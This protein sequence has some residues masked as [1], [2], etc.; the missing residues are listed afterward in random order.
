[1]AKVS[2]PSHINIDILFIY[3]PI[4]TAVSARYYCQYAQASVAA[5]CFDATKPLSIINYPLSIINYPLSIPSHINID[6][7][8][9]YC[10]IVTAVSARYYCQYAQASVAAICFDA[11]KPLSIINYPLSI[12]NYPLSIPSHINIDILF[13]YCPIVTAVSARYYCQYAQASVAAICFDAT[14]PLS[15]I[16]YPLSIINYPLS[17]PSHINIDILFI[18]CPIVTAVSA[19]YYCQY[20]QASV[21][22][23][24]FDATKPLSIINYPLSIINY[25]LSIPSHINIDILFI[26]CPIVTA[27][28][29]RYYCQYAQASVAAICFDATK[30]LSIINYPLSII[31]YPLSIIH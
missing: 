25:P 31:N 17:I 14:K 21:A 23:I 5:I 13:I 27:V 8:F 26:Y 2:A 30:P 22:A 24:C 1:M 15:I 10:P 12:I 29:A 28:S 20:A 18:Y 16:N 19:R 4:V 6:I 9:I 7:L 11:T 3:C